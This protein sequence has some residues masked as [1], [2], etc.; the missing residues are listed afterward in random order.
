MKLISIIIPVYNQEKY[1]TSCLESVEKQTY[2]NFEVI[3]VNDG[4]TDRSGYICDNFAVQDS[5]IHVIHQKNAGIG[6][7]RNVGMKC[8]TGEY[9]TF[10][11]SDDWVSPNYLQYMFDAAEKEKVDIVECGINYSLE[12]CELVADEDVDLYQIVTSQ[13]ALSGMIQDKN[14]HQVVWNKLYRKELIENIPF[15]EGKIHEDEYWTYQVYG[16]AKR[17]ALISNNLYYYYMHDGSIMRT[18]FSMSNLS[19]IDAKCKRQIYIEKNYPEI[20]NISG[21]DLLGTL[22]VLTQKVLKYLEG[23]EQKQGLEILKKYRNE[24]IAK[25]TFEIEGN[26]IKKIIRRCAYWNPILTA[27]LR[28]YFGIGL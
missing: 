21:T 18:T 26:W 27:K 8:S 19:V 9:I 3:V 13:V 25:M 11:D 15:P 23:E 4:S 24:T 28:N 16:N 1:L 7:A 20:K 6:V 2:G 17:I 10:I 22:I 12:K 14:F 5:R